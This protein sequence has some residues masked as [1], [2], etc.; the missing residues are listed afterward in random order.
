MKSSD[1]KSSEILRLSRTKKNLTLR[2]LG[3][4]IGYNHSY[5]S[6]IEKG[7]KIPS[8]QIARKMAT[9]LEIDFENLREILEDERYEEMTSKIKNRFGKTNSAT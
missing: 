1:L 3:H 5:I 7:M 4:L 6:Q 2:Q 9:I 8:D